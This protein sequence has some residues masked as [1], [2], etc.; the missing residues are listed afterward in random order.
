MYFSS[1]SRCVLGRVEVHMLSV[2][3]HGGQ[4][5]SEDSLESREECQG[6][7]SLGRE[8]GG[9]IYCGIFTKHSLF[10]ATT[11]TQLVAV[12]AYHVIHDVEFYYSIIDSDT[13]VTQVTLTHL[14]KSNRNS[15]LMQRIFLTNQNLIFDVWYVFVKKTQ[16]I[17]LIF[18]S[19]DSQHIRAMFDGPG[20][21]SA[22]LV[23]KAGNVITSTFQC[24]IFSTSVCAAFNIAYFPVNNTQIQ[25]VYAESKMFKEI[26]YPGHGTDCVPLCTFRLC[27]EG[28]NH[29]NVSTT[30]M[31]FTGITNPLDCRFG[32]VSFIENQQETA[33]VCMKSSSKM[34]V[35]ANENNTKDEYRFP[36]LYSRSHELLLVLYFYREYVNF[37]QVSLFL[38][39]TKCD[40]VKINPC[41]RSQPERWGHRRDF[42]FDNRPCVVLQLDNIHNLDLVEY[43]EDLECRLRIDINS[44]QAKTRHCLTAYFRGESV[45]LFGLL[46]IQTS[47]L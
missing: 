1:I 43:P 29:I 30:S 19:N 23:K 45:L 7:S 34:S 36:H 26:N 41:N 16:K 11:I 32:G 2:D 5:T 6:N 35:L 15:A 37:F 10:S 12:V 8:N 13:L 9:F 3:T 25:H 18:Y 21:E 20:S 33:S 39:V 40:L 22:V 44:S 46:Q 47:L 31:T 24:V 42:A 28:Q 14:L 17:H 38:T 4:E 27:T